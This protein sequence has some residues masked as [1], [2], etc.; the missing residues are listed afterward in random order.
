MDALMLRFIERTVCVLIGGMAIYLG[1]KLFLNLPK[2]QAGSGN[3][4]LP[5]DISIAITRVGPGVFSALFGTFAVCLS[6]IRPLQI[7]VGAAEGDT[8][9]AGISWAGE[10]R[11]R[12]TEASAAARAVLGNEMATLNSLP[13]MLNPNLSDYDRRDVDRNLRQVKLALMESVWGE[14]ES[15]FGEFSE[16]RQ[17]VNSGEKS[18]PPGGMSGALTLYR[19]GAPQ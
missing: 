18:D 15:G 7:D 2:A 5:W 16:F 17:W 13:Q 8:L 4:A 14:K 3:F 19:Y 10:M 6:L 9:S 12:D 11:D 1:Y